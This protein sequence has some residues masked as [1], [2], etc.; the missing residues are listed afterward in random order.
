MR[1]VRKMKFKIQ[2][3]GIRKRKVSSTCGIQKN[4]YFYFRRV[5]NKYW[6]FFKKNVWIINSTSRIKNLKFYE[7]NKRINVNL[8]QN[9]CNQPS[10]FA[11]YQLDSWQVCLTID[12]WDARKHKPFRFI[13]LGWLSNNNLVS[14]VKEPYQMDVHGSRAFQF[15]WT[16]EEVWIWHSPIHIKIL[17]PFSPNSI[18]HAYLIF[19]CSTILSGFSSSRLSTIIDFVNSLLYILIWS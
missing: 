19:L 16:L 9:P 17:L 6:W 2:V 8:N 11:Y 15:S 10:N 18:V 4:L 7:T 14:F 13:A 3:R 1:N 5:R 12:S